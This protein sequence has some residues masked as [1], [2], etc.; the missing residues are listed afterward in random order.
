MLSSTIRMPVWFMVK[1]V[2]GH[3]GII[4]VTRIV[5]LFEANRLD[6]SGDHV[7]SVADPTRTLIV[8]EEQQYVVVAEPVADLHQRINMVLLGVQA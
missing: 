2:S 5:N 3:L 4:D 6:D 1:D 8:M 7:R